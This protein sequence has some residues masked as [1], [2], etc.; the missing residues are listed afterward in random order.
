[1]ASFFTRGR[2]YHKNDLRQILLTAAP[3]DIDTG[4]RKSPFR[5]QSS[6]LGFRLLSGRLVDLWAILDVFSAFEDGQAKSSS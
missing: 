4:R 2:T 1:M 3:G 6:K 5:C